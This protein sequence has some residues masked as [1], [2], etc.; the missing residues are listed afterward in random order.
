MLSNISVEVVVAIIVGIITAISTVIAVSSKFAS[1]EYVDKAVKNETK[2]LETE[3]ESIKTVIEVKMDGIRAEI[4]S[5]KNAA[6]KDRDSLAAK[7]DKLTEKVTKF[8]N[9]AS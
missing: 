8:C 1:K 2:I 7:M 6:N 9:G 5:A 3:M 4:T